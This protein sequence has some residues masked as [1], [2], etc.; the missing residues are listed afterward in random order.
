M[1]PWLS[2]NVIALQMAGR[3][4]RVGDTSRM[5]A[6]GGVPASSR[7]RRRR[8]SQS[9][10]GPGTASVEASVHASGGGPNSGSQ[11]HAQRMLALAM[12]GANDNSVRGMGKRFEPPG[13]VPM[14]LA[15]QGSALNSSRPT[16][17][18][19]GL[20][21]GGSVTMGQQQGGGD[22]APPRNASAGGCDK[23]S[24]SVHG[25][26]RFARASSAVNGGT[27]AAAC[28]NSS[29]ATTAETVG[30]GGS[31]DCT[32]QNMHA[33]RPGGGPS[34]V[35][36]QL[37]IVG[38]ESDFP[39]YVFNTSAADQDPGAQP[40]STGCVAA[41]FGAGPPLKFSRSSKLGMLD[42]GSCKMLPAALESLQEDGLARPEMPCYGG[43]S[44][45]PDR[46]FFDG[47]EEIK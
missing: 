46:G 27:S 38:C 39:D 24:S 28:C 20:L 35:L 33:Q 31:T 37:G 44:W 3:V 17:Q 7:W 29:V 43:S 30:T 36:P 4:G 6:F 9:V 45:Q 1:K 22:Q 10:H 2:S 16:Q 13:H 41:D 14:V 32:C 18:Y 23:G 21:S 40:P 11:A 26:S 5:S 25:A 8:D 47:K 42:S 12:S 19:I 15:R 34:E